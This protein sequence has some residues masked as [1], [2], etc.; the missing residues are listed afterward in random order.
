MVEW[1]VSASDPGF[2]AAAS[3]PAKPL[4]AAGDWRLLPPPYAVFS[5]ASAASVLGSAG[6]IEYA[7]HAPRLTSAGLLLEAGAVNFCANPRFEGGTPGV[8]GSGGALPAD[9]AINVPGGLALQVVGFGT[10][11]GIPYADIRWSGT[12]M[13]STSAILFFAAAGGW[14]CSPGQ[15]FA[16]SLCV[17]LV[18]GSLANITNIRLRVQERQGNSVLA[19]VAKPV[20]TPDAS[21]LHAQRRSDTHTIGQANANNARL[22]FIFSVTAGEPVDVTFRF[23][24]PQVEPG[25]VTTSPILPPAGVPAVSTRAA[26]TL[27]LPVA[28]PDRPLRVLVQDTA[29]AE[30]RTASAAA[31]LVAIAPR[32]GQNAVRRA[33]A[34][35]LGMLTPAEEAAMAVPA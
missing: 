5:R 10:E 15:E 20:F 27:F 26:E 8:I 23:G 29:G 1:R 33:V 35:D 17:R 32:A 13:A 2:R 12:P 34:Y 14:V 6:L 7:A 22:N 30:W 18:D 31:G 24:L 4:A 16:L 3:V 9:M 11:D 19:H 25:S 21:P 28:W